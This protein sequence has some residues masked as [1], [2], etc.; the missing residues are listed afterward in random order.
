MYA[1]LV[2]KAA[3]RRKEKED[4]DFAFPEFDEAEYMGKEVEGAK[5]AV[6]TVILAIP[7]AAVLYG[8]TVAGV[9][10]VAFFL[11]VAVTF[12]LPRLFRFLKILPWPKVDTD[13]FERRDWLGHGSTFFFSWL[14]FWILFLN[15]P[16]VDLTAPAIGVTVFAGV[17]TVGFEPGETKP[18]VRAPSHPVVFNVTI[19]ENGRIDEATITILSNPSA[20]PQVSGSRYQF[21]H[22]GPE[23]PLPVEVY[24]RDAS[25]R[26]S[27]FSLNVL[28]QNP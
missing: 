1:A 28:L 10:V 14:A 19:L 17:S 8:L 11:G 3:K 21:S 7:V 25:G 18:V 20:L 9:A 24:A 6:L 2:T 22:T 13:K 23:T 12:A 26:E 27:T 16:F 4:S 5:A 15:V